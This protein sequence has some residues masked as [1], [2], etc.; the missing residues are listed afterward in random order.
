MRHELVNCIRGLLVIQIADLQVSNPEQ[1]VPIAL[2]KQF[3]GPWVPFLHNML[4]AHA[5][6]EVFGA[7]AAKHA[8]L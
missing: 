2:A 8:L 6:M 3:I 5:G 4:R 7:Q 1:C